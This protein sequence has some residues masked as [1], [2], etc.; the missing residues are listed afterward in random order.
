MEVEHQA[1]LL[2]ALSSDCNLFIGAGFSALAKDRQGRSLP[3]GPMLADELRAEF[4]VDPHAGLDLPELTTV[5]SVDRAAQLDTY[6][7]DRYRV[8]EV[9]PRYMALTRVHVSTIFTTNIDDLLQR[10]YESSSSSYLND[11]DVTGTAAYN[12][13]AIDLVHLHGSVRNPARP[14]RFTTL[15]LVTASGADSDRWSFLSSRLRAKPTIFLGYSLRDMGTLQALYSSRPGETIIGDPWIQVRPNEAG[16]PRVEFLR[17]LG[18]RLLFAETYEFLEFVDQSSRLRPRRPWR[19][20]F[21]GCTTYPP[22]ARFPF[23][24]SRTSL[25]GRHPPGATFTPAA[26]RARRTTAPSSI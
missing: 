26:W 21:A 19:I 2:K 13:V 23:D 18:F 5:I 15:D 12:Q 22:Q 11:V 17:A 6:L 7:R 1:S 25:A 14:L 8:Q 16:S 24:R 9:D 3:V 20:A 10:I 4:H